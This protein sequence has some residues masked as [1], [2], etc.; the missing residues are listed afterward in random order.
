MKKILLPTDFSSN[1]W[2]AIAYALNLYADEACLFFLMNSY[3]PPLSG[4]STTI[5]S[6]NITKTLLEASRKISKD[7]LEDTLQKITA[8]HTNALHQFKT[9]SKYNFF[10]EAVKEIIAEEDIDIIV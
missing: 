6:T 3:T 8:N 2:N 1:A 7:G 4:A 10:L 9:V 5:T